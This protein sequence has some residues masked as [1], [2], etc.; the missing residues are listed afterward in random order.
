MNALDEKRTITLTVGEVFE[1]IQAVHLDSYS[2]K[3]LKTAI[4][5]LSKI[6]PA[7]EV[8]HNYDYDLP[9]PL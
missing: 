2:E 3:D 5:K 1:L 7:V 8:V 6:S 4:K 9:K